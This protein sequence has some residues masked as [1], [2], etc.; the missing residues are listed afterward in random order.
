M[1][2]RRQAEFLDRLHEAIAYPLGDNTGSSRSNRREVVANLVTHQISA[3]HAQIIA[4]LPGNIKLERNDLF[5]SKPCLAAATK[6]QDKFVW[7]PALAQRQITLSAITKLESCDFEIEGAVDQAID[8][9]V[10]SQSSLGKELARLRSKRNGSD[11]RFVAYKSAFSSQLNRI[12][13]VIPFSELSDMGFTYTNVNRKS[14]ILIDLIFPSASPNRLILSS[15]TDISIIPAEETLDTRPVIVSFDGARQDLDYF[16]AIYSFLLAE[17]APAGLLRVDPAAGDTTLRLY[18]A[19]QVKDWIE[20][21]A[22]SIE[23]H[24]KLSRAVITQTQ[25]SE[26]ASP[27]SSCRYCRHLQR[28]DIGS[29]YLEDSFEI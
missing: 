10:E 11:P 3:N 15:R 26:L 25:F 9:A 5:N 8:E 23:N 1:T 13:E 24:V 2:N 17:V 12:G 14:D 20:Q 27:G 29:K 6:S 19:G 18:K 4:E 28:C 21:L 16:D 7:K 22:F